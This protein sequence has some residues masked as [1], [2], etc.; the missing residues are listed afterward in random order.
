MYACIIYS[1]PIMFHCVCNLTQPHQF[2]TEEYTVDNSLKPVRV[3]NISHFVP[4]SLH[5]PI[6]LS[7][8][9]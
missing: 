3:L 9:T 1:K 4:L 6:H 2:I 5:V 7:K 8:M